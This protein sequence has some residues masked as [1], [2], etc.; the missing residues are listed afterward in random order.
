ML[1]RSISHFVR[2][3]GYSPNEALQCA[4]RVGADLMGMKDELG[5]IREGFLADML[6]VRGDVLADVSLLEH[7][8]NIAMVM[9]DGRI[10]KDPRRHIAREAL[11]LAAE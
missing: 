8:D 5:Q 7:R 4:T 1:F 10:W 3:F 11:P 6:L 2:F 9:T